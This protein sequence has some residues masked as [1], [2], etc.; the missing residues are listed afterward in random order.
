M[1]TPHYS[2]PTAANKA[3]IKECGRDRERPPDR[4]GDDSLCASPFSE[5]YLP[6]S[7]NHDLLI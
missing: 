6:E 1:P 5:T 4:S 2:T 7:T 3:A